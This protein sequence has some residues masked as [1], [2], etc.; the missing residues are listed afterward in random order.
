MLEGLLM[1]ELSDIKYKMAPKVIK[2]FVPSV[3]SLSSV[4]SVPRNVTSVRH[5]ATPL[6]GWSN[7]ARI[8]ACK[9]TS[10]FIIKH[11][12]SG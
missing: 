5:P 6:R 2:P 3:P 12:S 8:A 10:T 4:P 9:P 1:L 7:L 11:T